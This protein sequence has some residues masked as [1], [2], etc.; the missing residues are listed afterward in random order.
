MPFPTPP[1]PSRYEWIRLLGDGA[2]GEVHLARDLDVGELRALKILKAGG[3]I[4]ARARL[5]H[6]FELLV[7][8][9]HPH[10]V[11]AHDF[12]RLADGRAFLSLEFLEGGTLEKRSLPADPR[13]ADRWIPQILDA[14]EFL[15][16][17][18]VL[19]LDVKPRNILFDS[20]L[21]DAN[22]KLADFGLSGAPGHG[23]RGGTPG[24]TAP[25]V[26]RGEPAGP[27]ADIFSAGALIYLLLTGKPC[28][29]ANWEPGDPRAYPDFSWDREALRAADPELEQV[30]ELMLSP[31]PDVRPNSIS[32]VRRLF[33]AWAELSRRSTEGKLLGREEELRRLLE[34]LDSPDPE[35]VRLSGPGGSGRSSMLRAVAARLQLGEKSARILSLGSAEPAAVLGQPKEV[36]LLDDLHLL[37][38]PGIAALEEWL[39]NFPPAALGIGFDESLLAGA[40]RAFLLRVAP[41][42]RLI[43]LGPLPPASLQALVEREFPGHGRPDLEARLMQECGGRPGRLLSLARALRARGIVKRSSAGFTCDPAALAAWSPGPETDPLVE[44]LGSLAAEDRHFLWVATWL[45]EDGALRESASYSPPLRPPL[46]I[47]ATRAWLRE[48]LRVRQVLDSLLPKSDRSALAHDTLRLSGALP[49]MSRAELATAAGDLEGCR[50]ILL[51]EARSTGTPALW[52]MLL[53]CLPADAGRSELLDEILAAA[54]MA[55]AGVDEARALL[56]RLELPVP[57]EARANLWRRTGWMHFSRGREAAAK[58]WL[59]RALQAAQANPEQHARVLA[60]LGWIERAADR[61]D[62]AEKFFRE[63]IGL[64]PPGALD[65]LGC[66]HNRLGVVLW[67]RRHLQAASE[68]LEQAAKFAEAAKSR[69]VRLGVQVNLLGVLSDQGRLQEARTIGER[70]IRDLEGLPGWASHRSNLLAQLSAISRAQFRNVEALHYAEQAAQ[71]AEAGGIPRQA[72]LARLALAGTVVHCGRWATAAALLE[73]D[74]AH[75]TEFDRTFVLGARAEAARLSGDPRRAA[76]LMRRAYRMRRENETPGSAAAALGSILKFLSESGDRPGLLRWLEEAAGLQAESLGIRNHC[77]L[78]VARAEAHIF[79]GNLDAAESLLGELGTATPLLDLKAVEFR[80]DL[81]RAELA[82]IRGDAK[83]AHAALSRAEELCESANAPLERAEAREMRGRLNAMQAKWADARAAF[84]EAAVAYQSLGVDHLRRRAA[85]RLFEVIRLSSAS[86]TGE[87]PAEMLLELSSLVHSMDS[88]PDLLEKSMDLLL[89]FLPA[90]RCVLL[91][92]DSLEGELRVAAARGAGDAV[93]DVA[94]EMS[95]G[96][97]RRAAETGETVILGDP[98]IQSPLSERPSV[99]RL[100]IKSALCMVLLSGGAKGR[101]I[102]AV[103]LDDRRRG[104][105]FTGIHRRL[106]WGFNSLIAVAIE[107]ARDRAELARVRQLLE[108]ENVVLRKEVRDAHEEMPYIVASRLM[109]DV[110]DQV[111]RAA[112]HKLPV[113]ILG[114]TGVGKEQLARRLHYRSRRAE[115]PF[116]AV[117]CSAFPP[118]LI[119]R[120]LFGIGKRVVGEVDA[121]PGYFEQAHGGTIFLDEIGDLDLGAQAKMLRVL[122]RGEVQRIGTITPI[123]VDIRVVAATNRDLKAMIEAGTFRL[124]LYHRLEGKVISVPPLRVRPEDVIP[125][126]EHFTA[127]GAAA[128]RVACP[129]LSPALR[130]WLTSR[131]WPGNVRELQHEIDRLLIDQSGP[132]LVPPRDAGAVVQVAETPDLR[133]SSD[134]GG[135]TILLEALVEAGWNQSKAAALLGVCEGTVRGRMKKHG[136]LNPKKS[137]RRSPMKP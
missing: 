118:S 77:E 44:R 128:M 32:E 25:E 90:E 19:H 47:A 13:D 16:S 28:F 103:Y 74:F 54:A 98:R 93:L 33:P 119:E 114:E 43:R 105:V 129:A 79:L 14:L 133:V 112:S 51:R 58:E 12:G 132:V 10:M 9:R 137:R 96:A 135:R 97:V 104:D 41:A 8:L 40:G 42:A 59:E 24:Y 83:L 50:G 30:I 72:E 113:L 99:V 64:A 130:G 125:L 23:A 60:D 109:R 106:L 22:L 34:F 11:E 134:P 124:D 6:E 35:S 66:L 115:G 81:A 68:S 117:N 63:G 120:E 136:V 75:L 1:L 31:R 26:F 21:P 85:D 17:Q 48:P 4:G 116:V 57:S 70:A 108:K 36:V 7:A 87:I 5:G 86:A 55:E 65:T 101:V 92:S 82:T 88:L 52:T 94:L 121:G 73:D 131:R 29:G 37:D 49:A 126:A 56:L 45:G 102:G 76:V 15:H 111:D 39:R 67:L 61:L 38:E 3:D 84:M 110:L 27:E 127:L 71:M 2:E 62:G 69:Q 18:G 80:A 107:Q 100:G 46:S 20:L 91:L 122:D 89:K 78:Q 53:D 95:L 123:S